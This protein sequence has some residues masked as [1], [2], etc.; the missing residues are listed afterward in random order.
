M[1]NQNDSE[2]SKEKTQS[3]HK[4]ENSVSNYYEKK[5]LRFKTILIGDASVGKTSLLQ[6]FI[7]NR[8]K[9]EYNCTIGV[10]YWVKSLQ[11]D[12]Q[13]TV[14]L[15]IWDTCGQERFKTI[16][17]Q[18][19]R[20]THGCILVFDLTKKET[21]KSI[22]IWIED[23]KNFGNHEMSLIVV[24]NKCD[25]IENREVSKEEIDQFLQNY[26]YEYLE[27]SALTGENV[28]LSFEKIAKL[29]TIENEAA[30]N[31]SIM[32]KKFKVDNRNVTMNKSIELNDNEYKIDKKTKCC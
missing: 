2:N 3:K 14:D 21:F 25:L 27:V 19:Y 12:N 32:K 15:Q 1:K 18:Y 30:Q 17:R 6:R 31:R 4:S 5:I 24:G 10:D 16:T 28:K 26:N 20:D 7:H 11:L 8:F 9:I 23:I 13:A 22:E 29:M